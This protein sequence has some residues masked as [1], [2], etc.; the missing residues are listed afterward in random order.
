[1][2]H[3]RTGVARNLPL[4]P[5]ARAVALGLVCA[6]MPVSAQGVLLGN[7]PWVS[8][9][10]FVQT[11]EGPDTI[12]ATFAAG[13]LWTRGPL[14][15]RA[16]RAIL[17]WDRDAAET[18]LDRTQDGDDKL[19]RRETS[20]PPSRRRVD[21]KILR[22]RLQRFLASTGRTANSAAVSD[23][24]E[25]PPFA[26]QAPRSI[27]LE[28]HVV[29]EQNG[30]EIFRAGS[31]FY[32]VMDDRG[33]FEDVTL[34]ITSPRTDGQ[35][36]VYTL[37]APKLLRQGS[38]TTGKDT[39]L[40]TCTAGHAHFEVAQGEIEIIERGEAFEI[41]SRHNRF[42][43]MRGFTIPLPNVSFFTDQQSQIPIKGGSIGWSNQQGAE[44]EIVL[45]SNWNKLGGAIH[46]ALTGRSAT[47]FRGDW[48]LGVG[49]IDFRGVP[50]DGRLNYE[51]PGLYKGQT[52]LFHLQDRGNN[53]REIQRDLTGN[54][55]VEDN[56]NLIRTENRF[57]LS[58]DTTLDLTVF[59]ASDPAVYSEFYSGQFY[60]GERPETNLFLRN[61]TEN[62]L[63]TLSGRWNLAGFSYT[64]GRSLSPTFVEELPVATYDVYSQPLFDLAKGTPLVF[65]SSTSIG[66]LSL[67]SDNDVPSGV[68]DRSVRVDQEVELAAHVQAGG[69]GLRPFFSGRAIH[70]DQTLRPDG[71]P[72]TRGIFEAG[73][74]AGTRFT[75]TF[76]WDRDGTPFALQ[77]AF[78]PTIELSSRFEASG[79]PGEFI[80]FDDTEQ[81]DEN[82]LVR[83]G[84][85]HRFTTRESKQAA[86]EEG[87]RPELLWLDFAQ[88]F[89]PTQDR[90]NNGEQLGLFEFEAILQPSSLIAFPR[91][92]RILF[93]GEYDWGE[94][95]LRTLNTAAAFR[96][97]RVNLFAEYRTDRTEDGTII[98]GG[99]RPFYDRWLVSGSSNYDL[100]SSQFQTYRTSIIRRD[101]DWSIIFQVGFDFVTNQTTF[102]LLFQPSFGGLATRALGTGLGDALSANQ[103]TG[104]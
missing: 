37:R 94:N 58:E 6:A 26:V 32:S 22:A 15:L 65:T 93:E 66:Q 98:F 51:A 75:R 103:G 62:R 83:V 104:F 99:S 40:T 10:G 16:D 33:V 13:L 90:D 5:A 69:F 102:N 48:E 55:I 47:E 100:E 70:Y 2:M 19:P 64:D 27:Y 18:L 25:T 56:R 4:A 30:V 21:D 36:I 31:F 87:G 14:R 41:R 52:D 60:A 34:R 88:N 49:F 29:L 73:V 50:L 59:D 3:R 72:F 1:M 68:Q 8:R 95:E 61:Q 77:H 46:Q 11:L 91:N 80:A 78:H 54:D 53:L 35:P 63:A 57:F 23:D 74:V 38:R 42:K 84:M 39:S 9:S 7:G 92:L 67:N 96:L 43:T 89:F 12:E 101:H 17:T 76:R 45:G 20:L 82:N 28:G 44:A 86:L 71:G 81:L 24:Q 97:E 85:L 79:A